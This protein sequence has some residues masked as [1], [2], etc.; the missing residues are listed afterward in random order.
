MSITIK[1]LIIVCGP[2]AVGKTKVALQLA[3][4][5]NTEIISADSRQIYKEL[6]IGTAKPNK[7]ELALIQHHFINHI[8]IHDDFSAG[9][10]EV[11]AIALLERLFEQ[12]DVVVAAGGTGLYIK[13]ITDGFDDIPSVNSTVRAKIINEYEQFGLAHLQREVKLADPEA[14]EKMD[15]ENPQRLMRVLEVNRGSG[16]KVSSLQ[17]HQ[18]KDRNFR[19]IKIGINLP[20]AMLYKLINDRVDLMMKNGL[21]EEVNQF[22]ECRHLNA[23]QTVGYNELYHYLNKEISLE[24]AIDLIKRNSRRYAKRQLT[25]LRKQ[26]DIHWFAP[27]DGNRIIEYLDG[28]L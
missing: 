8:S 16:Q 9:Q 26:E 25:W 2:T 12:N 4:H 23:L 19:V 3:Q 1:T 14:Y 22:Y 10:Y 28:V 18:K 6:S 11:E 5:F 17:K 13:A 15:T 21:L 7:E 20:R 27:E 24:E